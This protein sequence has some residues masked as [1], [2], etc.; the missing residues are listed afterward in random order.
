MKRT[1]SVTAIISIIF[2]NVSGGPYALEEVLSSG[3]GL[4]MLLILITPIVYS[5]PV[6]LVCAELGTALPLEGGYYAWSKRALGP[7]GAFCQ[8]WWAWLF[9]FVDI[10]IFPTM[11]CD[12][13]SY[14]WP[15]VGNHGDFWLR[16]AVMITMIWAFV[17]L[18]LRGAKTIGNFARI[19]VIMVLSP[20]V[21]MIVAG[22]YQGLTQGFSFSP[23][24]P[25][26]T[27][28]LTLSAALAAAIPVILWNYQ[29]WDAISTV[30][31]EMDNPRRDYPRGLGISVILISA[32]Y[33][34]PAL[35]V[36]MLVGTTKFPWV[37]GAWSAAATQ[38]A[39]P[40]LGDFTSA[41]GMISAVGMYSGLVLVY[42]R[43]PFVMGRDGYLP[44]ALMKRNARDVPYV[45]LIVSGIVYTAIIL[46]FKDLEE[47]AAADVTFYAAMMSLELLSFLVLRYREPNLERPFKVPGG[48]SVAVVLCTLPCA[49]IAAGILY[50]MKEHDMW[51][52]VV[53]PLLV[54][55][56]GPLLYPLAAAHC[57]RMKIRNAAVL[58]V[59][60]TGI[61]SDIANPLVDANVLTS[62]PTAPL[63]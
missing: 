62:P 39:G 28:G 25:I 18:N 9:T 5:A 2:F 11:F 21:L 30:A 7:F 42:S 13:L 14:F 47:L 35:I 43:V 54:M 52:V 31:G 40:W 46:I 57:R 59:S 36:L 60:G 15:A 55:S 23:V 51:E 20:F 29:G 19:F 4:A 50:R 53:R 37:T 32:M 24:L 17:L 48:W 1:L 41:M 22:I 61:T 16:K 27:P 58:A 26:I 12:Y 3:P 34:V 56:T 10:G 8:G 6:A 38:I 63:E 49:C 45:S 33:L 44:Q